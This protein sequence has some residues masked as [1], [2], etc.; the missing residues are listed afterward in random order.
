[1]RGATCG[2]RCADLC[3]FPCGGYGVV[4]TELGIELAARGH[5]VHFISYAKPKAFPSPGLSSFAP[6]LTG[7]QNDNLQKTPANQ[8]NVFPGGMATQSAGTIHH[9]LLCATAKCAAH[10]DAACGSI[11]RS[12]R[13]AHRA[14]QRPDAERPIG[15]PIRRSD[16]E[17][18]DTTCRES[19][20][21][22]GRR[23][24]DWPG[25]RRGL[26]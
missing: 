3:I 22:H 8:Q 13:V 26:S 2:M 23:Y 16:E 20:S 15:R 12:A 1:M 11:S 18:C 6:A 5:E 17:N 19:G 21:D 25:H 10:S 4:A 9:F 14:G 24:G 7:T